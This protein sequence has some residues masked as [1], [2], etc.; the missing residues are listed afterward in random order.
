MSSAHDPQATT[1]MVPG[2]DDTPEQGSTGLG[3][4]ADE[5]SREDS[6]SRYDP[7][8]RYREESYRDRPYRS[9]AYRQE[10]PR[11]A[12]WDEERFRGPDWDDDDRYRDYDRYRGRRGNG[13]SGFGEGASRFAKQHLRTGE[14]KEFFKTSEFFLTIIGAIALIIGAAVQDTF[15]AREMWRL[16]T[17][18]FA[19]YIISRG[20]AKAGSSKKEPGGAAQR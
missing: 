7:R 17:V 18:L 8:D 16:F 19:A 14:T 5:Y 11:P 2:V 10:R 4:D 20:I 9:E 6:G 3:S 15:D 13:D 12:R 1:S